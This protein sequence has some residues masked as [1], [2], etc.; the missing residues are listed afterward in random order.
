MRT[1][2]ACQDF[3]PLP[4]FLLL[5]EDMIFRFLGFTLNFFS[6]FPPHSHARSRKPNLQL[7]YLYSFKDSRSIHFYWSFIKS[8]AFRA[9][10]AH[11]PRAGFGAVA[12]PGRSSGRARWGRS[13]SSG[14][15]PR[16]HPTS[17]MDT[18]HSSAVTT[19]Q[20]NLAPKLIKNKV[21]LYRNVL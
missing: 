11:A 4:F 15:P 9:Q 20:L 8:S 17:A 18:S 5:L 13:R 19:R 3:S 21:F 6:M 12:T 14:W 7:I 2:P 16:R 10:T 1:L